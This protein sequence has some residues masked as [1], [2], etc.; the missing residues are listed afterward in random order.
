MP[1]QRN[2]AIQVIACPDH[3]GSS[4]Q[5]FGQRESHGQPFQRYRCRSRGK[6]QGTH[7]F[8]V[9]LGQD[10]A[11][12]PSRT[13][14]QPPPKCPRHPRGR[15]VR[16]GTYGREQA[17]RVRQRYLCYHGPDHTEACDPNCASGPHRFTPP[18][19]RR[20][21]AGHGFA[22][23]CDLC[24]QPRGVHHG[25]PNAARHHSF[26]SP[27]VAR[28]LIRLSGGDPYG[29]V[30]LWAVGQRKGNRASRSTST[31]K[32]KPASRARSNNNWHI[33]ADWTEC[34][35]PVIYGPLDARLRAR[36]LAE[37]ARIDGEMAAGGPL[38]N[39]LIWI[40][41]EMPIT[42]GKL[43]VFVVLLVAE[44][45]W[46]D[47]QSEPLVR[48]RLARAMP[49]RTL[50]SWL[51]VWDELSGPENLWPDFLVSDASA[52]LLSA[53]R[54][55]LDNRYRWVPS[56]WHLVGVLRGA[57]AG[58]PSTNAPRAS[59]PIESHLAL[60]TRGSPA[61]G[62]AE[63][64]ADWWDGLEGLFRDEGITRSLA[65]RRA[66]Y[67]PAFE[68]AIPDLA[69]SWVPIS[70]A[71]I[72]AIIRSRLRR[73]FYVRGYSMTSIER[74]NNLLDLAVARAH[75]ALDN[76]AEVARR[77]REDAHAHGGWAVPPRSIN[78]PADPNDRKRRYRSLRDPTLGTRL[79]YE[80]GLV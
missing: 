58:V 20:W 51:V 48:L 62:S 67:G 6:S 77:L 13:A 21:I 16:D 54:S 23:A 36:A 11:G 38:R 63:G 26:T 73:L 5:G 4:V 52:A 74:T 71:A 30:G 34:F 31:A 68:A 61:L 40:A 57:A 12:V 33:A 56:V 59:W 76:E 10:E 32:T 18:L 72:E 41:D 75:G 7:Y 78:D 50:P 3:R 44:C 43:E 45:E 46:L 69:G 1:F 28:G 35:A 19:A 8:L 2:S 53:A 39:P 65:N 42:D 25:E 60:L 9:P 15:V 64:W 22:D 24:D 47:G 49:D 55:R 80:R 66:T 27:T 70:N 14:W 37:R 29:E 79:A 17:G